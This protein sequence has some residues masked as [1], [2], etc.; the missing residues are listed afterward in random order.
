MARTV[1]TIPYK[2]AAIPAQIRD[3]ERVA[4]VAMLEPVRAE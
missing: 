2:M 4:R 1:N 3:A